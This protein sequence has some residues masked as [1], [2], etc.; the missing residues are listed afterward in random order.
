MKTKA[1]YSH[2]AA[3]STEIKKAARAAAHLV[4]KARSI[5]PDQA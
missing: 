4:E 1:G 2:T 5:A 3:S